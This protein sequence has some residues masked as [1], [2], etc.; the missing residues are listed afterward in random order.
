M[1]KTVEIDYTD[2][3]IYKRKK[4]HKHRDILRVLSFKSKNRNK[5]KN[6]YG[7]LQP[8][9]YNCHISFYI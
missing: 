4:V 1:L 9:E 8:D 3:E 5:P 6:G 7:A 2:K